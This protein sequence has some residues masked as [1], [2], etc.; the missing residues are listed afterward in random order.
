[1]LKNVGLSNHIQ[2]IFT[3]TNIPSLYNLPGQKSIKN[4]G[5]ILENRWFH[6]IHSDIIWPL[7]WMPNPK[8][9]SRTD[10]TFCYSR[11]SNTP[12]DKDNIYCRAVGRSENPGLPV[13]CGG[14]NPP[15]ALVEIGLTDLAKSGASQHPWS[16]QACIGPCQC[17]YGLLMFSPYR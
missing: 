10:S 4:F 17:Q 3:Q 13:S 15:P 9:K 16:R 2:Y 8:F 11:L 6:K 12:R 14:H 5:G 7:V 1:M